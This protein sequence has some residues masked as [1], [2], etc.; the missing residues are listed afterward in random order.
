RL[1]SWMRWIHTG[2]AG[3]WPGQA[4]AGLASAGGALLVWTGLALAWRRWRAWRRRLAQNAALLHAS[5]PSPT[6]SVQA[7]R[8]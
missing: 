4:V 1:R 6:A 8:N 5:G 7:T 3:G 2:E